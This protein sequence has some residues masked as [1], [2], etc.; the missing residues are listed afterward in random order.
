[1]ELSSD[2]FLGK[3]I[4]DA[5]APGTP[6]V[7]AQSTIQVTGAGVVENPTVTVGIDH[8]WVGDLQ[9]IL[10]SPQ[11]TRILLLDRPGV[12]GFAPIPSAGYPADLSAASPVAF[13]DLAP[14]PAEN[15]GEQC[16]PVSVDPAT[17]DITVVIDLVVG[18][19]CPGVFA[20]SEQLRALNGE[21]ADG[22]WVLTV[23]DFS[24]D[25][26][27]VL[28]QWSI[29]LN[30]GEGVINPGAL[31]NPQ[32]D[33]FASGIGVVSGWYCDAR[34]IQIQFDD[35]APKTAAYGTNRG[36]TRGICGDIDNG[37][38]L[39]WNMNLLGDGRHR[40]R[41]YAD[42][43]EFASAEFNVTTLGVEFLT[44][45]S[46]R[47]RVVDFPAAG[48]EVFLGWQEASQNFVFE[49]SQSA[50]GSG[51]ALVV[52]DTPRALANIGALEN[53]QPNAF[54]SGIGVI[55]GW[56]CDAQ[57]IQIQFDDEAPKTAAYGTNRG[58]TRGVCGDIDNGFGLLW[59]MNLLGDGEHTI[60]AYADG[61]QFAQVR[62]QVTTLGAE[63]VSGVAA[64]IRIEDF[65]DAGSSTLLRWQEANQN[66]VI[67]GV[68]L[69]EPPI[70]E[71]PIVEGPVV[72]DG[73][74]SPAPILASGIDK[75]IAGVN[76]YI[77]DCEEAR[78]VSTAGVP[79]EADLPETSAKL[80]AEL[81]GELRYAVAVA[82]KSVLGLIDHATQGHET[83]A[84]TVN[85][86]PIPGP[87]GGTVSFTGVHD[88]GDTNGT[89]SLKD[90]CVEA[91]GSE[92]RTSGDLSVGTVGDPSPVGPV[93]KSFS[94]STPGQ[95]ELANSM[96]G[97]FS[98]KLG[99]LRYQ[100]G[101]PDVIPDTPT[102]A[103]P[104]KLNV[105][106][107]LIRNNATG[108]VTKFE[109]VD[110][111]IGYLAPVPSV[112]T[113]SSG[114]V[115][116]TASGELFFPNTGVVKLETTE[117]MVIDRSAEALTAAT[118]TATGADGDTVTLQ[119]KP[120]MPG[121]FGVTSTAPAYSGSTLDCESLTIEPLL[122]IFE[123]AIRAIETGGLF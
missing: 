110:A 122:Q 28:Q 57:E 79:A 94:A 80:A 32:P 51:P 92:T 65:P 106:S 107:L 113:Q 53:P 21:Q 36:D 39:L 3:T 104:D 7:V 9:I 11:G 87:C 77:P 100:Y 76:I 18:L 95:L 84:R 8:A 120:G 112:Y 98:V 41:A 23:A 60:R 38:G 117:P 116:V 16:T 115:Q 10:E 17:G 123:T 93:T 27:G 29:D 46:G 88:N 121:V 75:A 50:L 61:V 102:L 83:L 45:R 89:V 42:G 24:P 71:P 58:D 12:P 43:V 91:S 48:G 72:Y 67:Q 73:K 108:N 30:P 22:N 59:N 97:A 20:P 1:V 34:E 35:E 78:G 14:E 101:R 2:A 62:F 44:G 74:V 119:V 111:T 85:L 52:A 40:I 54:A 6:G 37:F 99:G 66:F 90:F 31:E 70:I 47:F 49:P 69:D 19:N 109:D 114:T 55:S 4:G 103:N 64:Q 96:G 26:T 86:P 5:P 68:E 63:F 105:S 13:D 118:I 25:D 81:A 33:S 15:M 82:A 56:Y